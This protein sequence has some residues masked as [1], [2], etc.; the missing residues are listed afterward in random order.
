MSLQLIDPMFSSRF[1][2]ATVEKLCTGAVWGEGPVWMAQDQSVLWSDIP[3]NRMLRWSERDGISV[4]RHNANFTNGHTLEADG[5]LLHCSHGARAIIRTRFGLHLTHPQ[6]E[7]VVDRF[8]GG[9]LNSP[10]DIT[11]KSD[12]TIWFT[13]PP[14]GILSNQEGYQAESEQKGCFVFCFNPKTN[15]LRK[16]T[17]FLIHPNGLAFSPTEDILY[18]SDTSAAV[19]PDGKHHIVAF[20]VDAVSQLRNPRVFAVI[21][22]GLPDGFRVDA[23]G[24]LFVSSKDSVQVFHPNGTL[25][26]KIM[27]PEKV[28]NLTF[29]GTDHCTIYV[30]A[31][32]SLY[33][34]KLA[35]V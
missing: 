28:G 13:D 23:Q 25:L 14:Y 5:S 2:N 17:D 34:V 3:N 15:A 10:N 27:I 16:A 9:R 20:D 33:R 22:P 21:D 24:W 19:L 7:V 1:K 35:T 18:V 29:A 32:S 12:G 31:S 8:E 11:V 30:C 6:D 4:W 26:A